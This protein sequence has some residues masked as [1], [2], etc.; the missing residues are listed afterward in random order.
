MTDQTINPQHY[1]NR[2]LS[3]LEFNSR[4]LEEAQDQATPL[5]ERVKFLSIFSSNLDEFYMVRVAGLREQAFDD[6][7]PQDTNPDGMRAIE[8]LKRIAERSRQLVAAQYHCLSDSVLPQLAECGIVIAPYDELKK[9]QQQQLGDF[10]DKMAFPILTPMAVDPSHPRPRYHNRGLYLAVML[11][12][13]SGLGPKKLFAVVQLPLVL[14]RLVPVDDDDSRRVFVLLE[15]LVATRLPELFGGFDVETSATFRVT[16]DSDLDIIEQESDDMLRMIE[17]RLRARQRADA[18][19]LEVAADA[20]HELVEKIVHQ[21]QL[22]DVSPLAPDHYS[23]VYHI[24]GPLD[25]TGLTALVEMPGFGKLHDKP[26]VPQTPRGLRRHGEEL[27]TAIARRDIML[28]HPYESFGPVIEYVSRAAT[29][30]R[31]LAIKQTLYRTSGDSPIIR[32]LIQAAENGKHVTALVELQARFDEEANVGWARQMERA[33]VHVVYG[34]MDL[35]THCKVSLVVRQEGDTVRRYVHLAT[36]NYNPA[37]ARVYTDLGLFTADEDMVADASALFNLLTGYSQGHAWRKLIVAPND[38]RHKSIELIDAQTQ[39]GKEGR[40]FAKLNSLSDR[41]VIEALYRAS[42]AGVEIEMVIRGI[43]GLRP[44]IGGIS[45]NIRVRSIVGRFLEHSRILVFGPDD[46]AQVFFSSADWMP[47][48]LYRRVEVMFPVESPPIK[49]RVLNEIIPTILRDNTQARFL[50]SD[51]TYL[52][53]E[54]K[55]DM[56][57]INSQSQLIEMTLAD[58]ESSKSRFPSSDVARVPE[59]SFEPPPAKISP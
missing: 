46:D 35:K 53:P 10:F 18:V 2:E 49:K 6:S 17:E 22:A 51:G 31:V 12:R 25:L 26:F 33:G 38:L 34:F 54:L 52:R 41:S 48:N 11:R 3:W 9:K 27:I 21:E 37:T 40:I 43:C 13:R 14:P 29:D 23:E 1:I 42:G 57:P 4:V 16:R 19:R 20:D 58:A 44:G 36:G 59:P 32:A 24:P 47:R 8:Q 50:Q 30:P 55:D 15:D 39:L 7:A 5:L 45:D 56:P 28:H